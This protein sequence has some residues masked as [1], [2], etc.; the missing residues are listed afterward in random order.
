MACLCSGKGSFA[1]LMMGRALLSD[2]L[3]LPFPYFLA[4]CLH[5]LAYFLRSD[6]LFLLFS[7]THLLFLPLFLSGPSFFPHSSFLF[8]TILDFLP[9]SDPPSLYLCFYVTNFHSFCFSCLSSPW[10]KTR[11]LQQFGFPHSPL[12]VFASLSFFLSLC[13][14]CSSSPS[15]FNSPFF[16]CLDFISSHCNPSFHLSLF[17]SVSC[18][19]F[20]SVSRV[21][22]L[23]CLILPS[24]AAWIL[25]IHLQT[26]PSPFPCFSP[27]LLLFLPLC[28]SC[29]SPSLSVFRL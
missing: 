20:L 7:L 9:R 23:R 15:L 13:F 8:Y 29:Y 24:L 6:P 25:F 12:F 14:W 2:C 22:L 3:S 17:L 16:T 18:F 26:L 10:L 1:N 28:F 27:S 5:L 21:L 19:S 11:R 4:C